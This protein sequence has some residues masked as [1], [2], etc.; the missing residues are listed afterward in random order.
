[1]QRIEHHFYYTIHGHNNNTPSIPDYLNVYH[2]F[3]GMCFKR[4]FLACICIV[5]KGFAE[6]SGF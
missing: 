5:S 2:G 6:N 3:D 1:M 4:V